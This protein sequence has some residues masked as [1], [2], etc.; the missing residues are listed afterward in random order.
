[1]A[2]RQSNVAT[3]RSMGR[4][5]VSLDLDPTQQRDLQTAVNECVTRYSAVCDVCARHR[6]E[7]TGVEA[8]VSGYR[9]KLDVFLSW[10]DTTER[11]AVMMD[12]IADDV[13]TVQRQADEQRV[14]LM[15]LCR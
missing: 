7:L 10:L 2:D 1:M 6:A 8:A 11:S 4:D 3:L 5:I 9:S 13:S 14:R 12:N 15:S